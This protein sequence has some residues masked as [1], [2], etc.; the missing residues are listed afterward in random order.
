MTRKTI[1]IFV[2][3][4]AIL[5]TALVFDGVSHRHAG[6]SSQTNSQNATPAAVE[7]ANSANAQTGVG[8]NP[9]V[10]QNEAQPAAPAADAAAMTDAGQNAKADASQAQTG[11]DSSAAAGSQ[12]ADQSA[13]EPAPQAIVVPAGTTLTVRLAEELGSRIS[14]VGQR[15]SATLDRDIVVDGQTVIPAGANVRGKVVIAKSVG[16]LAGEA[17]LQLKLTSVNV[18]NSNL[19]LA[20]ATRSFGPQIKGK[21]KVGKFMKGLFK[22]ADGQEREVLLAEQSAYSFT[23]RQSLQIQ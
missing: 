22:R 6:N 2:L 23:L 21:N 14:T 9:V 5:S 10:G 12:P 4:A 19:A 7:P 17:N 15:F 20:T 3:S 1:I 18:N 11:D 16:Q 8:Q 13:A